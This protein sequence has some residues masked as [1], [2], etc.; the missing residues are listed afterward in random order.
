MDHSTARVSVPLESSEIRK[1]CSDL[2]AVSRAHGWREGDALFLQFGRFCIF[3]RGAA[4]RKLLHPVVLAPKQDFLS[5]VPIVCPPGHFTYMDA[6]AVTDEVARDDAVTRLISCIYRFAN[7]CEQIR[8]RPLPPGPLPEIGLSPDAAAELETRIAEKVRRLQDLADSTTR[9]LSAAFNSISP[10]IILDGPL[11]ELT[12]AIED[13]VGSRMADIA[14]PM[15]DT[16]DMLA[17]GGAPIGSLISGVIESPAPQ[18]ESDPLRD[19]W[20]DVAA[21]RDLVQSHLTA[22]EKQRRLSATAEALQAR[23]IQAVEASLPATVAAASAVEGPRL[24][25][26]SDAVVIR[27]N[28]ERI[29]QAVAELHTALGRVLDLASLEAQ[30]DAHERALAERIGEAR[31]RQI[32][33]VSERTVE[34]ERAIDRTVDRMLEAAADEAGVRAHFAVLRQQVIDLAGEEEG[35]RILAPLSEVIDRLP[36]PNGRQSLREHGVG[37]LMALSSHSERKLEELF[38][39]ADLGD[40]AAWIAQ[41]LQRTLVGTNI[42]RQITEILGRLDVCLTQETIST[43]AL[44][45]DKQALWSLAY[46]ILSW[47][48]TTRVAALVMANAQPLNVPEGTFSQICLPSGETLHELVA[49]ATGLTETFEDAVPVNSEAPVLLSSTGELLLPERTHRVIGGI[50]DAGTFRLSRQSTRWNIRDAAELMACTDAPAWVVFQNS[51]GTSYP[52]P[53]AIANVL[54]GAE[55]LAGVG[56]AAEV[57]CGLIRHPLSAETRASLAAYRPDPGQREA[58][59]AA[60]STC[61]RL[62]IEFDRVF[63]AKIEETEGELRAT[64]YVPSKMVTGYRAAATS[65]KEMLRVFAQEHLPALGDERSMIRA[66]EEVDAFCRFAVLALQNAQ[67]QSIRSRQNG[68]RA[69]IAALYEIDNR[70]VLLR[71][72]LRG[73]V[74]DAACEEHLIASGLLAPVQLELVCDARQAI[75][76]LPVEPGQLDDLLRA[77]FVESH[78]GAGADEEQRRR[79]WALCDLAASLFGSQEEPGPASAL[80]FDLLAPLT[81][82]LFAREHSHP[83]LSADVFDV[84]VETLRG[85][86]EAILH[87]LSQ[88]PADSALSDAVFLALILRSMEVRRSSRIPLWDALT[89][90]LRSG[91]KLGGQRAD[92]L[93][94][95]SDAAEAERLFERLRSGDL[96]SDGRLITRLC[97]DVAKELGIDFRAAS[98]EE[99]AYARDDIL[100][101]LHRNL[102]RLCERLQPDRDLLLRLAAGTLS[103]EEKQSLLKSAA[104]PRKSG[105][106]HAR[107]PR[108]ASSPQEAPSDLEALR[109]RLTENARRYAEYEHL[110]TALAPYAEDTTASLYDALFAALAGR[111]AE[112]VRPPLSVLTPLV[113]HAPSGEEATSEKAAPAPEQADADEEPERKPVGPV[114]EFLREFDHL[115]SDALAADLVEATLVLFGNDERVRE[116]LSR[117]RKQVLDAILAREFPGVMKSTRMQIVVCAEPRGLRL[118]DISDLCKMVSEGGVSPTEVRNLLQSM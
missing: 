29:R 51:L 21:L 106:R 61:E 100:A 27:V 3:V 2:R 78:A 4:H 74:S 17:E 57:W 73:I 76:E 12:A 85:R 22:A 50:T 83:I 52:S 37:L 53:D 30:A 71:H 80:L 89:S 35:E 14:V 68:T 109:A 62:L 33:E 13:L 70:R 91:E 64:G 58:I 8:S 18:P 47:V 25:E 24:D 92:D 5:L 42:A 113:Q 98:L 6:Q 28:F 112:V 46:E 110:A 102:T 79:V 95:L 49:R 26:F 67:R 96:S 94:H 111:P 10:Q 34:G 77:A 54:D 114:D 118:H 97:D 104:T 107:R 31:A 39:T 38:T 105:G 69:L 36:D 16:A 103:E 19:I 75:Q 45:A 108:H 11:A 59:R 88:R 1:W 101:I 32:R 9:L 48:E 41:E 116:T 20:N 44:L 15:I 93:I 7:S 63:E 66:S 40:E 81:P 117:N 60:V 72:L 55:A 84:F 23:V 43:E 65:L 86:S 115:G 99:L 56:S 90:A 82:V 87:Y